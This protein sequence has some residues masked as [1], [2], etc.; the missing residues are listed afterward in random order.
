MALLRIMV[1]F[2]KTTGCG[3]VAPVGTYSQGGVLEHHVDR[4][5]LLNPNSEFSSLYKWS[6]RE[7]GSDGKTVGR[8]QIPWDWDLSFKASE[9]VLVDQLEAEPRHLLR[10][11][12]EETEIRYR[13][14]IQ[15]K[16]RPGRFW[17]GETTY[18]MFGT[19]RKI[20]NFDLHI[21]VLGQGEDRERCRA[22]GSVSYTAEID[23]REETTDDLL[24]FYLHVRPETFARYAA[25]ISNSAVDDVMFR[26][27]RVDGFYS[28]WSPSIETGMVKVLTGLSEQAVEIPEGCEIAPPR[29]GEVHEFALHLRHLEK[30]EKVKSAIFDDTGITDE[31]VPAI[32]GAVEQREGARSVAGDTRSVT[33]L[34][35]LRIAAWI[36]TG[37]LM[38]ILLKLW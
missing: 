30:L 5:I 1:I 27:G 33:L 26:V 22:W 19:D 13:Q 28:D 24:V 11:H 25:M 34:S 16:L 6:L 15:A 10:P 9:L 21:E 31:D 8:D 3:L 4:R 23:I 38:A 2:H 35:S 20:S 18:S 7:I 29:L 36:S 37:L 32:D 17:L 14:Y 12:G